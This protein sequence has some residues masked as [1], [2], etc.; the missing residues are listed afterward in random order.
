M[1]KTEIINEIT[2]AF[3]KKYFDNRQE[4]GWWVNDEIDTAFQV[5]D[6]WFDTQDMLYCICNNISEKCFFDAYEK[7]NDNLPSPPNFEDKD[8]KHLMYF[9]KGKK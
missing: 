1:K 8:V 3:I 5:N 4:N 2:K 7:F 9:L 6:Y